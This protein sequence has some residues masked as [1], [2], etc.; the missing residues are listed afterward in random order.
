MERNFSSIGKYYDIGKYNIYMS[1]YWYYN[2]SRNIDNNK[3]IKIYN[4]KIDMN[5]YRYSMSVSILFMNK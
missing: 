1:M 2:A 5:M 4:T 3:Y